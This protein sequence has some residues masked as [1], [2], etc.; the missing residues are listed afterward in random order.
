MKMR[1][2]IAAVIIIII[3]IAIAVPRKLVQ[4]LISATYTKYENAVSQKH[5]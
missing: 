2:I 5:K 4:Y 1:M 3:V